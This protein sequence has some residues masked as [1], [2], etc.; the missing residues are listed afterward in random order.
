[1]DFTGYSF[2][3]LLD[4]KSNEF[5]FRNLSVKDMLYPSRIIV[6]GEGKTLPFIFSGNKILDS[7]NN[8]VWS[9]NSGE[10]FDFSI[11]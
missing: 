7:L 2:R 8:F 6:S 11:I 1:M 5:Y 10:A 9:F 4:L 3:N